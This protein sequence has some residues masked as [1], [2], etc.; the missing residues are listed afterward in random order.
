LRKVQKDKI[1]IL[2]GGDFLTSKL[3]I[4]FY[5]MILGALMMIIPQYNYYFFFGIVQ[6][7]YEL[8]RL[9]GLVFFIACG[10]PIALAVIRTIFN[11]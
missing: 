9:L 7:I 10:V 4:Y 3:Q 8:L 6:N 1:A 11:K 5:G 2:I